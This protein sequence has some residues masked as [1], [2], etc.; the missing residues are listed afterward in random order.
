V[1]GAEEATGDRGGKWW[2][3]LLSKSASS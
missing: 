2:L 1:A 3:R